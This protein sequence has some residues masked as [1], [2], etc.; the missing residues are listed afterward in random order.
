M[1]ANHSII[2][3]TVLELV[4]SQSAAQTAE[5]INNAISM[6][7]QL[8]T[9][10]YPTVGYIP[11]QEEEFVYIFYAEP[12][13]QAPHEILLTGFKCINKHLDKS[14]KLRLVV[15]QNSKFI[16]DLLILLYT[17]IAEAIQV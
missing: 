5:Y 15:A 3:D 9:T 2:R 1:K 4:H 14:R 6:H 12:S 10:F 17:N 11:G 7:R 8:Y 16:Q 13:T